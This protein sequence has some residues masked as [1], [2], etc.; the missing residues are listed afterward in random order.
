MANSKR[1]EL[2]DM[3]QRKDQL[4]G[5]S[6]NLKVHMYVLYVHACTADPL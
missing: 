5:D 4:C 2:R 6:A 3:E 1:Q